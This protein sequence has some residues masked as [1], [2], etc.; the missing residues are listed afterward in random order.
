MT[1]LSG[2][3]TVVKE[4]LNRVLNEMQKTT[5]NN[6]KEVEKQFSEVKKEVKR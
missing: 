4:D 3:L 2:Q 6:Q 5:T 1:S